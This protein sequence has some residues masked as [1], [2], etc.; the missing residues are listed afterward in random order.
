MGRTHQDI[1]LRPRPLELLAYVGHDVRAY[2]LPA[3]GELSLGRASNNDIRVEHPSVSRAHLRLSIEGSVFVEDLG[4]SNGTFLVEQD[5]RGD[6]SG[7]GTETHDQADRRLAP[8]ERVELSS[9]SVFRAGSVILVVQ[10]RKHSG[11]SEELTAAE[12]RLRGPAVLLDQQMIQIYELATRAAASDISVLIVGE[13]GSGKE[14]LADTIHFRSPRS[15]GPFLRLNCAALSESLL[16]SELFGYE[17]GAF[18][19]ANQTRVG[20]LESSSG[21]TVFLDE[22]G[23]LPGSIQV[24]LL[25]VIEERSVRRVG[26]NRGRPIDVR[27][28]TA[29]NRDLKREASIGRFRKDLYF[30]I[31]GVEVQVPPLRERMVEIEPLAR[32]FLDA[33]CRR[34]GIPRPELTAEAIDALLRYQWPG[35]VRE[36]RNAMERAPILSAGAPIGPE[37]MPTCSAFPEAEPDTTS[38]DFSESTAV[39]RSPQS[40]SR[41][42]GTL[43]TALPERQRILGALETCGGNQT[44][45]AQLLGI[46]R[47]TLINRLD[48]YGVPRPRKR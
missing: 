44:R 48:E 20:L 30:R 6:R 21:G 11:G 13:T 16:E 18:T 5:R 12:E 24:K 14:V 43:A 8:G 22:I 34:S 3:S 25:R 7:T 15:R 41:S 26:A 4:S 31:N 36:L 38:G 35:N 29:T 28:I 10:A 17:R 19:G 42:Q 32:H 40:L 33:F 2:P 45:A 1:T 27:F 9:G 46:S 47:R 37:H 23:E 39:F